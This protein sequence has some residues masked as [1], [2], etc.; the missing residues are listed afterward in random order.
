MGFPF[1]LGSKKN[2]AYRKLRLQV[3][4]SASCREEGEKTRLTE[5]FRFQVYNSA[6]CRE[7]GL[8]RPDIHRHDTSVHVGIAER[9][10][11]R[12]V[13]FTQNSTVLLVRRWV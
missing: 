8:R 9:A 11:I 5:N 13:S 1:Q 7:E 6:S 10:T 12:W 4:N 3:N 2:K